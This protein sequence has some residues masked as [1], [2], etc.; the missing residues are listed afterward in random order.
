[1]DPEQAGAMCTGLPFLY[2]Y[3]F[4]F[5][6]DRIMGIALLSECLL[7]S[8]RSCPIGLYLLGSG[9]DAAILLI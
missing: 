7:N 1:L 4:A 2:V 3:V 9:Q 6:A 5:D 8:A